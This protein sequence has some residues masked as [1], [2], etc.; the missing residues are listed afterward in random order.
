MW[1]IQKV[2]K[3]GWPI[4]PARTLCD[5]SLLRSTLRPSSLP[6][7]HPSP[8]N[9]RFC[10]KCITHPPLSSIHRL[11]VRRKHAIHIRRN[12]RIRL[13]RQATIHQRRQ[14]R[15]LHRELRRNARRLA[16]ALGGGSEEQLAGQ[17]LRE[18][19]GVVIRRLS[20]ASRLLS[21]LVRV[22]CSA[23]RLF[24]MLKFSRMPMKYSTVVNFSVEIER[25][26]LTMH[27]RV[28]YCSTD[29]GNMFDT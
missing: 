1:A 16:V 10:T 6:P 5:V 11:L 14:T 15:S 4:D 21:L 7:V 22:V 18:L 19:D 24:T 25:C 20:Y 26:S 27:A 2:A 28:W 29:A 9:T 13:G 8:T 12:A 23:G 3:C 17:L